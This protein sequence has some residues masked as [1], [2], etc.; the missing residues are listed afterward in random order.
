MALDIATFSNTQGGFPFFK[1]AGHPAV[2]PRAR[3]LMTDLAG[4][5][6]VAVY[7]PLGFATAFAA[8]YP[9]DAVDVAHVLV[10]DIGKLGATVLGCAARPVT[11]LPDLGIDTLLIVAFDAGK[12]AGDIAHLLPPGTRVVTLDAIRLPDDRLT[13]PAQ[14]L[15]PLNFA[16]NFA[17]FRDTAW[18]SAANGDFGHLHTR[19]ATAN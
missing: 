4:A 12:L 6:R 19:I 17:W 16:T 13:N 11:E 1:A 14:Y 10:Q 9:L 18:D 7:D 2:A 15:D 5:G 8:I 3:A